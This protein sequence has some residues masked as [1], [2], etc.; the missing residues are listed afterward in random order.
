[1]F[2][3]AHVVQAVGELDEDDADIVDHG[4]HHFAEVLGLRFFSGREIDFADLGYTLDDVGNL[5]AELLA[6]F[7]GGDRGVFDGV[8]EETGGDGDGIHLHVGENVADFERMHEV[9]FAGRAGL[10]GVMFL[11]KFV[12]FFYE[13][14]IV[15]GTVLAQLLHQLAEA[16]HRE[17]VGRDLLTQRRHV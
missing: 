14:E 9:R 2:E 1:M 17:H 12:G 10:S 11:G 3:G 8:V 6:N 4:K 15:V 7:N 5:F 13:I 16:G